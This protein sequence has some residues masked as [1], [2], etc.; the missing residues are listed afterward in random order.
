M[1]TRTQDDGGT[2]GTT[3][4]RLDLPD[5]LAAPLSREAELNERTLP[6][7]IRFALKRWLETADLTAS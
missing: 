3:I 1:T 7:Q 5:E 4:Y 6:G 2:N